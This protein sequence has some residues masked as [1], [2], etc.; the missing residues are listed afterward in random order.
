[1]GISLKKENKT[2]SKL[3][4]FDQFMHPNSEIKPTNPEKRSTM[5]KKFNTS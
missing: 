5:P 4:E 3:Y 2:V 1:M